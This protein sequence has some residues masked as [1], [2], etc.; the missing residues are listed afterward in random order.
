MEVDVDTVAKALAI[1]GGLR[2]N[3]GGGHYK[4]IGCTH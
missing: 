2:L 3:W 4:T 1:I